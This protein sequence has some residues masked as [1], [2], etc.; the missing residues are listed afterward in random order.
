MEF[1][2]QLNIGKD[3]AGT[4]TGSQWLP[5]GAPAITSF[6]PV[7]G[8][9]I[10]AITTTDKAGYEAVVEAARQAFTEWRSWPAP[11]RGE[12]VRQVGDALRHNKQALGR[13]VSYE[14]GKSLQE[15]YGEVQEMIDICDLA[16]GLSRQL[17]GLTMHSERSAHR[18]YEQW[19]PLG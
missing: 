16:V 5:S 6:S 17:H 13:L 11:R 1:L 15:G 7:D 8:K 19:H 12:V 9:P 2:Q 3:N 18:M 10:A 14:M 4:A